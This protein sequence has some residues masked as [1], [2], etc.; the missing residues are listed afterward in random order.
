MRQAAAAAASVKGDGAEERRK[1]D[2]ERESGRE[3]LDD[4]YRS[5]NLDSKCRSMQLI[6]V[7]QCESST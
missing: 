3:G 4:R 6:V 7:A 5:Q 1:A 2:K